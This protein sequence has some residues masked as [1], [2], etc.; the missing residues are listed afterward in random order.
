[1]SSVCGAEPIG[2]CATKTQDFVGF[3]AAREAFEVARTDAIRPDAVLQNIATG[4]ILFHA[5]DERI[6][7]R[8]E[9]GAVCHY[10]RYGDGRH[11]V[12]EFAFPGDIIGLGNLNVHA[13]TAQAMVDT[14]VSRVTE[15]ELEEALE[16][17]DRI[18]FRMAAAAERDFDFLRD[19]AESARTGAPTARVANFLLAI[20]SLNVPEGR[21]PGLISDDLTAGFVADKLDMSIEKLGV[22]L[23]S[24]KKQGAVTETARG[25]RI[26]DTAALQRL[27]DAA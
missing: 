19:K 8:V 13:T 14:I 27:A 1:M 10:A 18:S 24:L 22:A 6:V 26:V 2:S 16:H 4:Q 21:D 11:E 12:L 5:G 3:D 23:L 9:R 20:S 17:D 15:E 7:Y 25:L